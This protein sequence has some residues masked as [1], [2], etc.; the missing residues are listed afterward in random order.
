MKLLVVSH[1]CVTAV[2]QAFFADLVAVTGWSVSI[3]M[4]SQWKNAYSSSIIP[5]TWPEGNCRLRHVPVFLPGN[6]PV[7]VYRNFLTGVLKEEVPDAIYVHNEPYALSTAQVYMANHVAGRRPIGF[8]TAQNILKRYPVPF[9]NLESWVFNRSNFAFPVT[10]GAL[11]VARTKGYRQPAEVLPLS[12]DSAVYRPNINLAQEKRREIG[13]GTGEIVIG[14]LGRLVEEKGLDTLLDSLPLLAD[15]PYRLVIVGDGPYLPRLREVASKHSLAEK[16]VFAGYVPHTEAPVWLSLFDICV[17]P[18][19]TRPHWREQFGRVIL[20]SLACGTPVVGSDSGEIPAV[21]RSTGS[22]EMIFAEG[23][24]PE[25]AD[26]LA[27]LCDQPG[28]RQELVRRG[29]LAIRTKYDQS[30]LASRFASVVEEAI[31]EH[32]NV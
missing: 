26:R 7:H 8:Y 24:A 10:E 1:A 20:E 15:R 32:K 6:I 12:L 19:R 16:I 29:Q 27:R 5:E 9:R 21:L 30:H 11:E 14:F 18:S 23:S 31:T 13:I 28:L 22:E 3:M 25:L 2:N 17:L 4:P